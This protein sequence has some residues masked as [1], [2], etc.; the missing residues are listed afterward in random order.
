MGTELNPP[1]D[2]PTKV[3]IHPPEPPEKIV[4]AK[5]LQEEIK[6]ANVESQ[7]EKVQAEATTTENTP[8]STTGVSL[9][10]TKDNPEIGKENHPSSKNLR[11]KFAPGDTIPAR[12]RRRGSL[13]D[14]QLDSLATK[15]ERLAIVINNLSD[16]L[17]SHC[18]TQFEQTRDQHLNIKK[19]M[20]Y[21]AEVVTN[22]TNAFKNLE[23]MLF[24]I[25][26][27]R[28]GF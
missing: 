7:N 25:S 13:S 23:N 2:D 22:L 28:N 5:S 6:D 15:D 12:K 24:L 10:A 20:D 16:G 27:N 21:F 17:E 19:N 8:G 26:T 4:I 3:V 18:E 11:K 9:S 1:A 14:A